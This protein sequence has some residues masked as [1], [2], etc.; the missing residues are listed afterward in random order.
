MAQKLRVALIDEQTIVR[1]GVR[2]ILDREEDIEVV[3]DYRSGSAFLQD[4]SE[5]RPNVALVDV[6]LANRDDGL[7]VAQAIKDH[8]P[9]VAILFLAQS[10][11]PDMVTRAFQ[12]GATGFLTK[13]SA[14]ARM[15]TES[16]RAV[17]RGEPVL[18]TS[19]AGSVIESLR[20][21]K[22]LNGAGSGLGALSPREREVLTLVAEGA[23]NLK[24][25]AMLGVSERT[26]KAHVTAILRK[27]NV[28][29]RTHAALLAW[30]AGI[31]R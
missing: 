20:T 9:T 14:S 1:H 6:A 25:A 12:A 31:R 21:G 15:L 29:N 13:D 30:E 4:V 8:D 17:A 11:A 22:P 26:V 23:D 3:G 5:A 2:A 24:I 16:I 19:L 10:S 27:L 28:E 7:A 18:P